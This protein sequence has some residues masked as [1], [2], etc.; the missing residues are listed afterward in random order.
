MKYVI[1]LTTLL[2]L[3][4]SAPAN[5]NRGGGAPGGGGI[6]SSARVNLTPQQKAVASYQD[7]IKN[8]D[9]AEKYE[10]KFAVETRDKQRAKLQKKIAKEYDK[11][12]K[13]FEEAIE[14]YPNF[15]QA[16]GSLGF[17]LRKVSRFDDSL[18]AYN[19]SLK[20]N[21]AYGDAIEYRGEA[22][23]GLNRID[24][25]KEA[26]MVLFQNEPPLAKQ[27]LAA[28]EEWVTARRDDSKGLDSTEVE[29][30][31]DWIQQRNELASFVQTNSDETLERWAETN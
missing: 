31:A 16:H 5:A 9:K 18:A 3:V 29:H 17:A 19:V 13:N 8:R 23:L 6:Q 4:T 14:Y 24:D 28:M 7:G 15:Y 25:A 30:F 21:P 20:I 27:L 1:Y 10:E 11:A 22:F 12:I 26:Y 2:F